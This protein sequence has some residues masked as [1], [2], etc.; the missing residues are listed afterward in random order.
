MEGFIEN[1]NVQFVNDKLT[2]FCML[3]NDYI[4]TERFRESF[5]ER[6]DQGMYK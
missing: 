3:S 4:L 6:A 2:E 1:A 5:F